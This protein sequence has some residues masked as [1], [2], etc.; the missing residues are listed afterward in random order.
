MHLVT[1][2]KQPTN[3]IAPLDTHEK[4]D[5]LRDLLASKLSETTRRTYHYNLKYFCSFLITGKVEEKI[6]FED[7]AMSEILEQF[8]SMKKMDAIAYLE[9]YKQLML[10]AKLTPNT[11]NNRTAAVKALVIHA[12]KVGKVSYRL[13]LVENLKITQYRD[14][15]GITPQQFQ[16]LFNLINSATLKGKRDRAILRL[17]WDNGLRRAEVVSLDCGDFCPV[18]GTLAIMGKGRLEPETIDLAPTTIV[19]ISDW[20]KARDPHKK[21]DPLFIALDRSSFGH[22]LTTKSVYTLIRDLG[23]IAVSHK[24]LS[25]HRIRHSSITALLEATN[26]NVRLAQNH[27]RHKNSDI[28]QKYDDNRKKQ[29]S[30][31]CGIV[32]GLIE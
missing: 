22:R 26:G 5:I 3:I 13:D 20:L 32:A 14:T 19:A 21:S 11:I 4:E 8:L 29:Q 30:K 25:P 1:T 2:H 6:A 31:A 15:T 17:L 12:E 10:K 18:D 9:K 16:A 23:E 7:S 24:I 28:T 27:A